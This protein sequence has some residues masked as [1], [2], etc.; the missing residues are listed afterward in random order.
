MSE[1]VI[2]TVNEGKIRG[3]KEVSVYS[4]AEYYAFY[5]IPYAEQPAKNLRFKVI[6][7]R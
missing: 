2:V 4:K 5:G 6:I 1:K 7:N 3:L